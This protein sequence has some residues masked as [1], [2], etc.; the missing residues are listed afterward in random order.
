MHPCAVLETSMGLSRM[1]RAGSLH[2]WPLT[3]NDCWKRVA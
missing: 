1:Y 2:A 3:S